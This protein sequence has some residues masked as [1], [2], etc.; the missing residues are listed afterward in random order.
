MAR[1]QRLGA[2]HVER[3]ARHMAAVDQGQ[4]VFFHQVRATRH[5]DDIGTRLQAAQ[6]VR[7][8]TLAV[9]GVSGSR[10]TSTGWPPESR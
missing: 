4:Q 7:F 1:R 9:S 8:M 5:V 6:R 3:G 2:E 10:L